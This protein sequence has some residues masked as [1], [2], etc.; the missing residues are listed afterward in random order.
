MINTQLSYN[1][2]ENISPEAGKA[3]TVLSGYCEFMTKYQNN[4][5]KSNDLIIYLINNIISDIKDFTEY[6]NLIA[7]SNELIQTLNKIRLEIEK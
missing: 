4:E 6:I 5:I 7:N 1:R 3:F 2:F